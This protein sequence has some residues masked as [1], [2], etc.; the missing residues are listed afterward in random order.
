MN[1]KTLKTTFSVLITIFACTCP[2]ATQL[3]EGLL[4][5]GH[6]IRSVQ[7]KVV[8]GDKEGVWLFELGE[9][10]NDLAC[11]V[12][13][14]SKLQLLPS[15]MLEKLVSNLASHTEGTYLITGSVTQYKEKNYI[16]P[17]FFRA[18]MVVAQQPAPEPQ[19]EPEPAKKVEPNEPLEQ[20][21][22]EQTPP[23]EQ[24]PT[25]AVQ[26]ANNLLELPQ[27]VLDRIKNRKINRAPNP[28][29]PVV[30]AIPEAPKPQEKP[31]VEK[32]QIHPVKQTDAG[33]TSQKGF[34]SILADRM[35]RLSK[36]DDG[37]FEFVLDAYGLS[38]K[39]VSLHLL[40][41]QALELTEGIITA[42]PE[43]STFK[44]AGIR[45]KYKGEDYLLLQ[46][47]ARVY[48]NGNFRAFI[49]QYR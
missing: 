19:V 17:T 33:T 14:G 20:P 1:S 39:G 46:R 30:P 43:R 42:S 11:V 34:D 31:S 12:K 7:G 29:K 13:A 5:D 22:V 45:T 49:P 32:P 15:I 10:V 35:G 27:E 25:P 21:K 37:G 4:R 47:V 23:E 40:P 41:C 16:Y 8:A 18:V 6:G 2:A 3:P 36:R 48:S 44:I 24:T 38:A 9:D 26:D 28:P